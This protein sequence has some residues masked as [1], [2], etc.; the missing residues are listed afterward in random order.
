MNARSILFAR[1]TI[2]LCGAAI[3]LAA[4]CKKMPNRKPGF[5]AA[6]NAY[7]S[8][9]PACLWTD[10][11]QFP[12][13]VDKSDASEMAEY[14]ALVDQGL[15]A[16]SGAEKDPRRADEGEAVNHYDLSDKGRSA[17]TVDAQKPGYGNFCYG[18]RDVS[19]IDNWTPTDG[20]RGS[21]SVVNYHY[22]VKGAPAWATAIAA[23]NVFPR[24]HA[25]LSGPQVDQALLMSNGPGHG[26]QVTSVRQMQVPGADGDASD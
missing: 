18:H 6:I 26:W 20:S 4:G 3:L 5:T 21:T 17:W 9:H 14:N 25:D 16:R 11:V 7:Y 19:S 12:A 10:P 22:T 23:Q 8:T 15:L 13:Q 24:L 1:G 2:V